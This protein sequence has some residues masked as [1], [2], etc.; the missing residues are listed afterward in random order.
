MIRMIALGLIVAAYAVTC[1]VSPYGFWMKDSP[2]V[3]AVA[4]LPDAAIPG[5]IRWRFDKGLQVRIDR[6]DLPLAA[7][8]AKLGWAYRNFELLKL[9]FYPYAGQGWVLYSESRNYLQMIPLDDA[10]VANLNA[11]AGRDLTAGFTFQSWRYLWGW[12]FVALFAVWLVFQFRHEAVVRKR[13]REREL[14]GVEE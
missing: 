3:E 9:P 11:V 6:P 8:R 13:E 5:D 14:E 12:V 10:A 4:E 1:V 7:S 2:K